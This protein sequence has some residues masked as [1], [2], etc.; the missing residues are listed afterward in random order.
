MTKEMNA[1]LQGI[2]KDE[3]EKVA[4]DLERSRSNI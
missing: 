4:I 3:K 2:T 1:A